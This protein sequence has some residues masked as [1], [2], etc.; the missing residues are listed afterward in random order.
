MQ[1][2]GDG[3]ALRDVYGRGG[4]TIDEAAAK[5]YGSDDH[6]AGGGKTMSGKNDIH[7]SY[8]EAK[9]QAYGR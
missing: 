9:Q 6:F 5:F 1:F 8:E 7:M 4:E 3:S 2:Y